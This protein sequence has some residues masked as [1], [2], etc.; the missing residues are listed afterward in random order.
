MKTNGVSIMVAAGAAL[1]MAGCAT[2]SHPDSDGWEDVFNKDLSNAECAKSGWAWDKDGYL[3]PGT[4]ETLFSKKDYK[5]FVL[6][7]AYTM[8]PL[9]TA[10]F[11]SMIPTIPST[12]LR[13]RF[14]T[15]FTLA[16]QT[17]S[18]TS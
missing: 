16:I 11:S 8:D 17:K 15:I 14:S 10:A 6:D 7:L 3:T 1:L 13:C 9:Q 4:E 18:P 2:C 12:S 5:N